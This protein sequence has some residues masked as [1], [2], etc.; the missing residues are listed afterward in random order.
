MK[1]ELTDQFSGSN[2]FLPERIALL[3]KYKYLN[4]LLSPNFSITNDLP[5]QKKRKYAPTIFE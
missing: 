1:E 5:N 2:P 3:L 4:S